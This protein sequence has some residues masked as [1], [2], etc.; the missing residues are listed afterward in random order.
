M[1]RINYSPYITENIYFLK[2]LASTKS[3]KKK[4]VLLLNSSVDQILAVIEIIA[5]VLKFNFPL[6]LRQR[7]KLSKFADFYRSL[8]RVKTER[9][10]RK[11][12]QEGGAIPIAAIL[13]P[14]LAA[15]GHEVLERV[16]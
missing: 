11:R 13:V 3:D 6:N 4:N 15:I 12:L 5:N 8:A 16:L 1:S 7:R 10:A 9:T 14:I 2:K